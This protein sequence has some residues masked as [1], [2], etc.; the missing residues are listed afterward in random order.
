MRARVFGLWLP[1][2]V[3][4]LSAALK[5]L[6]PDHIGVSLA[7][8]G[9]QGGLALP[10]LIGLVFAE[11][12]IGAALLLAPSRR[13]QVLAIGLLS[14]FCLVL[15][16]FLA[17]GN[18][19]DCGCFGMM[20]LFRSARDEGVFGVARNLLLIAGLAWFLLPDTRASVTA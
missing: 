16:A 9:L 8:L 11:A 17:L 20:K 2:G 13:V 19:P 1:A 10:T 15:L 18:P 5:A 12:G 3:L 4:L 14:T 7:R 6:S